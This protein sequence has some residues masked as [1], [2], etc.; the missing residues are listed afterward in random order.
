MNTDQ[1][2]KYYLYTQA[3]EN[4]KWVFTDNKSGE[5][6]E[7]DYSEM[8]KVVKDGYI[9]WY[10]NNLSKPP[11]NQEELNPKNVIVRYLRQAGGLIAE[12]NKGHVVG[13]T[14]SQILPDYTIDCYDWHYQCR[15]CE[16]VLD[17]IREKGQTGVNR[18]YCV[19]C[20][21]YSEYK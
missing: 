10:N 14:Y 12:I 20:R 7:Y 18:L 16:A 15:H 5:V 3:F 6:T 11:Y 17:E 1:T 9:S 21:N 8:F 19:S 4:A 2:P 13:V